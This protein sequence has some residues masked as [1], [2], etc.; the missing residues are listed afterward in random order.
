LEREFPLQEVDAD[1]S[2]EEDEITIWNERTKSMKHQQT[3]LRSEKLPKTVREIDPAASDGESWETSSENS[4]NA[5][6]LSLQYDDEQSEEE[7]HSP[8]RKGGKEKYDEGEER[9][10][11]LIHSKHKKET[12]KVLTLQSS[13]IL[14]S[15]LDWQ[16]I[17][18][19]CLMVIVQQRHGRIERSQ[20]E[21]IKTRFDLFLAEDMPYPFSSFLL[22]DRHRF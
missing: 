20:W 17:A 2:S 9:E 18:E 12:E 6:A 22:T 4:S 8:T 21:L 19:D 14:L 7:T 16:K 11:E 3:V 13:L 15:S 1:S 5:D 10:A